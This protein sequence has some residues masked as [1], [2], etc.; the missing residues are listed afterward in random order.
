MAP[1]VGTESEVAK[2]LSNL[3]ELDYD[4]IKAYREAIDR[5]DDAESQ[6]EL[7]KFMADHERDTEGSAAT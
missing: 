1:T 3:I 5:I 4:A 2:R 6:E 7:A